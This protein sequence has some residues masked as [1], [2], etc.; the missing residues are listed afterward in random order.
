MN[1]CVVRILSE[2]FKLEPGELKESMNLRIDFKADS[3]D[4]I[5]MIMMLERDYGI[6]IPFGRFGGIKTVGD[7]SEVVDEVVKGNVTS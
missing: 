6:I 3:L 1:E 2:H 4:Y 7:L 5:K